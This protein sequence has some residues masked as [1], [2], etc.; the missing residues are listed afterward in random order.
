MARTP[1]CASLPT[2]SMY[3]AGRMKPCCNR[4]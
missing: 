2:P 4:C 1:A 3:C